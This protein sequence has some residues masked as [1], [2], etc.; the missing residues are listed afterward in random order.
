MSLDYL[1]DAEANTNLLDYVTGVTLFVTK[2]YICEVPV[3]AKSQC[4]ALKVSKSVGVLQDGGGGV[5]FRKASADRK[6][7]TGVFVSIA[8]AP[9]CLLS[10]LPIG[11]VAIGRCP[12]LGEV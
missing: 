5:W 2:S 11:S 4:S 3:C 8:G 9:V 7:S 1:D 12:Y 6:F 10:L